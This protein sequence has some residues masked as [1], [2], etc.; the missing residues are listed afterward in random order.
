VQQKAW[1]CGPPELLIARLKEVEAAYPGLEHLMLHFAEG[2]PLAEFKKQLSL[3]AREVM[4]AFGASAR[5]HEL[6]RPV[7]ASPGGHGGA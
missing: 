7:P 3:F 5:G 4:P 1:L 6:A 2:L